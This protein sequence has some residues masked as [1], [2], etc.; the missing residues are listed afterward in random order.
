MGGGKLHAIVRTM[1][2][3]LLVTCISSTLPAVSSAQ[4]EMKDRIVTAAI[5][6]QTNPSVAEDRL[7]S[8]PNFTIVV[9]EDERNGNKDIYAQKIDNA[10]GVAL[11][12]PD[13]VPV[14]TAAYEQRNPRAACDSAG[15]VIV[16][17]EDCRDDHEGANSVIYAMRLLI[18]TGEPDQRWTLDGNLICAQGAPCLRPRIAGTADGAF[19][20]WTARQGQFNRNAFIQYVVS[21]GGIQNGWPVDGNLVPSASDPNQLN[22][23]VARDYLWEN[24]GNGIGKSGAVVAYQDNR[25][26][27][28]TTGSP[29]WNVFL[30]RFRF[31]AQPMY[32]DVWATPDAIQSG[33][34]ENQTSLQLRT[35]GK[36]ITR[37]FPMA[38]VCWQDEREDPNN[39]ITDIWAQTI[40]VA[41]TTFAAAPV[42][43]KICDETGPQERT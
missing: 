10:T 19:I 12:A 13:G 32:Q 28:S 30:S 5:S 33:V 27:S 31:D 15:G 22:P 9:F 4:V 11:W 1:N 14:C 39:G 8:L 20:V 23:E 36:E 2:A 25:T 18:P 35:S 21:D 29:C 24:A 3:A 17:W 40:D 26:A 42:G 43:I 38:V 7:D 37:P 16:T 34:C 41:G 6:H